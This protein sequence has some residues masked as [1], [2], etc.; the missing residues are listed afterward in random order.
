MNAH[1]VAVTIW[2]GVAGAAAAA[3]LWFLGIAT[4]FAV[5]AGVLIL[6]AG[7][8]WTGF[9]GG[10]GPEFVRPRSE[11]RPGTRSDLMQLAWSLRSR[12]GRISDTGAKR[13]RAFARGRLARAGVD[14][15]D[16]ADAG[17]ARTLLGED[18]WATLIGGDR[19][20]LRAVEHCLDSLEHV[21]PHGARIAGKGRPTP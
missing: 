10:E 19:P 6:A 14:I 15:D 7:V 8:A 1:A 13:L 17:V 9:A 12:D 21:A 2:A 18:A 5:G 20:G 11:P 3:A 16:P 4:P